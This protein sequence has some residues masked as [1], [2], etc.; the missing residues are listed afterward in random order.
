MRKVKHIK[1]LEDK[2][3]ELDKQIKKEK[4]RLKKPKT[5]GDKLYWFR[6]DQNN[7]G[8]SFH[9]DKKICYRLYLQASD[10][11][12]ARTKALELGVY[13]DGVS[14]GID[15][16]CC[17]DRWSDYEEKIGKF[18]MEYKG[19]ISFKDIEEYAQF[20]ANEYGGWTT[21]DIRLYYADGKVKE[22][23]KGGEK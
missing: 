10:Y 17:G 21:P 23:F 6:F 8:G 14:N 9:V 22:I 18:P 11:G 16:S 12:S 19:T 7:S 20:M 4:E 3:K 1:Q 5:K 15:C 2:K 13:F